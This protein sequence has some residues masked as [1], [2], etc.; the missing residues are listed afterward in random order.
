MTLTGKIIGALVAI[1]LTPL[2]LLPTTAALA[3]GP[4]KRGKVAAS[5]PDDYLAPPGAA[6]S[7]TGFSI[8]AGAGL[9]TTEANVEFS[10]SGKDVLYT[11]GLGYDHQFVGTRIVAGLMADYSI[12]NGGSDTLFSFNFDRSWY[13]GARLG[14]L[15][16]DHLLAYGSLGYTSVD[17]SYPLVLGGSGNA[18]GLTIGAGLE[19]LVTKHGALVLDYRHVDLGTP[20][21]VTQLS[22]DELRLLFKY[23]F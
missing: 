23:R 10:F 9:A 22:Q 15:L 21:D 8:Y 18:N 6:H 17:G 19:F 16:S 14:G 20:S 7:W 13:V 12:S 5:Q 2:L 4:T 1:L 11:V 3:D